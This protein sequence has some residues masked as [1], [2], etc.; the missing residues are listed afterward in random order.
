MKALS[1]QIIETYEKNIFW[2]TPYKLGHF[3]TRAYK[4]TGDEKY[5]NI[6]SYFMLLN[7]PDTL[8]KFF[9]SIKKGSFKY[10]AKK[11]NLCSRPR[12]KER[13]L[14]YQQNPKAKLYLDVLQYLIYVDKFNLWDLFI[15][16]KKKGLISIFK[17]EDFEKIFLNEEAIKTNGSYVFNALA[18]LNK[19][20]VCD[21]T[22]KALV[23]FKNIYFDEKFLIKKK[24]TTDDLISLFYSLTHIII[25]DTF[26]YERYCKKYDWIIK[27]FSKNLEFVIK[28]STDDLLAEIGLCF[29]LCKKENEFRKEFVKIKR[30]VYAR[31]S[32]EKTSD[33]K[34][35]VAKE[36]MSSIIALLF[37]HNS[38][39]FHG[40]DLSKNETIQKWSKY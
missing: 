15:P 21:L 27:F 28:N 13:Y 5:K 17:K 8:E 33:K 16:G 20:E 29:K 40:P 9:N 14:Y 3:F 6:L 31:F 38:N 26:Y 11:N 23:I 18:I 35:I 2:L 1:K 7:N 4:I 22:K 12:I 34:T 32:F 39:F 24:L 25:A 37:S 30:I 19:L 36:H 10:Q